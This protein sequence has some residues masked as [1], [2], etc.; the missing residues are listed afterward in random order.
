MT[1]FIEINRRPL[2][3]NDIFDKLLSPIDEIITKSINIKQ[4]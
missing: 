1:Y 2:M 4:I 3:F